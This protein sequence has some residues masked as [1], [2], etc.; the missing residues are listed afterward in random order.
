MVV[1]RSVG[2]CTSAR[3]S[4]IRAMA[5][6]RSSPD[7]SAIRRA[8]SISRTGRSSSASTPS[9]IPESVDVGANRRVGHGVGAAGQG[10]AVPQVVPPFGTTQALTG[11]GPLGKSDR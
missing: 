9:G 3:P 1:L 6:A 10:Q 7:R 8:R 11:F 2:R 4:V 5:N